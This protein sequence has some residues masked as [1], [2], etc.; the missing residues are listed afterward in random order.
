M[1]EDNEHNRAVIRHQLRLFGLEAEI[2]NN[3]LEALDR[4]RGG[5]FGLLL[6]DL[7]M[8]VMDGYELATVI[9]SEER[10]GRRLPI[11]ALSA[12]GQD[13][14]ESR[15][16]T[17]GIDAY[18]IKPVRLPEL[19]A[20]I[21]K[22]VALTDATSLSSSAAA[23]PVPLDLTILA[24][25]IGDDPAVIEEVLTAFQRSTDQAIA[26]FELALSSNAMQSISDAAHKL[27]S[28]AR[29]VGAQQ[30]GQLCA[31]LE[32]AAQNRRVDEVQLLASSF[33]AECRAVLNFLESR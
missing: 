31:E 14:G 6:T 17:S 18:V 10:Q 30:L 9:R 11:I 15:W 7:H 2:C 8:P 4:W 3:G 5:D 33:R 21:A 16:R 23:V 1:A 26:D 32:D 27:K 28:A 12:N 20:V 19:R 24:E 13:A 29:S 22:L 25:F